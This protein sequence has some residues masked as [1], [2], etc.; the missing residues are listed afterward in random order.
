MT[1]LMKILFSAPDVDLSTEHGG[2]TH[3]DELA[4]AAVSL[5]HD[6]ALV[7]SRKKLDLEHVTIF[8]LPQFENSIFRLLTRFMWPFFITLYLSFSNNLNIV[9][10][11]GRIFGGGAVLAAWL[12]RKLAIYEMIEPYEKLFQISSTP[13]MLK[14]LVLFWHNFVVRLASIVICTH[15]IFYN[16]APEKFK[17]VHTGA[18]PKKFFPY[19]RSRDILRKVNIKKGKVVL[20]IGSFIPWHALEKTILAA[21]EVYAADK[22]IRFLLIGKGEKYDYCKNLVC[23]LKLKNVIFVGNVSYNEIPDYINVADVCL[24]LFDRTHAHIANFDYFYSP[25]KVHEYKA[26]GKP[27]VASNIGTL[28][29]LVKNGVNGLLVDEQNVSEIA[30]AILALIKNKKLA[31]KIGTKNREEIKTVYNWESIV[32]SVLSN[33]K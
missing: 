20:Y 22:T 33:V 23:D 29:E 2:A 10:E 1:S 13:N 9:W 14:K 31:Q 24:A 7:C 6:V 16:G 32:N 21:K 12:V 26:C 11:R 27:I 18:N 19:N 5:G 17:I 4:K 25:I 28:K 15:P 3:V 8:N 30:N